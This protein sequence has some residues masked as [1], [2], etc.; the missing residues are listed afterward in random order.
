MGPQKAA[1]FAD[2]VGA[3]LVITGHQPQ[4]RGWLRNGDRHLILA[5]DH[6]RGVFAILPLDKKLTVDEVEKRI[7][8]FLTVDDSG[9]D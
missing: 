7:R 9:T 8:Q 3:N 2:A 6:N 1:E 5:S 4:D